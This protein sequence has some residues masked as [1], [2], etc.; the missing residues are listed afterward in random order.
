MGQDDA[1]QVTTRHLCIQA[2]DESILNG[3]TDLFS[4]FITIFS[5]LNWGFALVAMTVDVCCTFSVVYL[6][7]LHVFVALELI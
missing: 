3:D 1:N 4:L 7:F 5:I 6:F 2:R